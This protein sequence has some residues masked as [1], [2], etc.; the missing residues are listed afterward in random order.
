LTTHSSFTLFTD[1]RLCLLLGGEDI[2]VAPAKNG[3][4]H[5][6][7]PVRLLQAVPLRMRRRA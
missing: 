6:G 5:L 7:E 1:K 3:L 4:H 2:D